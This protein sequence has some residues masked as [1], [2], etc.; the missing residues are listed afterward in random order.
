MSKLTIISNYHE[1]DILTWYDLTEKEQ[2]EFDWIE[3]SDTLDVDSAEFVRYRGW[4]YCLSDMVAI[5]NPHWGFG[6]NSPFPDYWHAY[7][8]DNFFSGVL[9]HYNEDYSAVVMGTYLS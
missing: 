3:D 2:S 7:E 9:V 8:G 4:V 5:K 1:R 6:N